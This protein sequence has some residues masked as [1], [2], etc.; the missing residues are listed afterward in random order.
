MLLHRSNFFVKPEKKVQFETEFNRQL[1]KDFMLL[2]KEQVL[3][4]KLFGEGVPH[5]KVD[6]FLGDYLAVAIGNISIDHELP[7]WRNVH[8]G[9]HAGLTV[10]EMTV[11]LIVV[12][13]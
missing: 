10:D 4:R 9:Q 6:D 5:K 1:G 11:P 7:S 8:K 13:R 3:E 12:E 2:T